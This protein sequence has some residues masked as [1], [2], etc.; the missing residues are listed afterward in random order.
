MLQVAEVTFEPLHPAVVDDGADDPRGARTADR[1]GTGPVVR[2]TP[3]A[4]C[5]IPATGR[6]RRCRGLAAIAPVV[7]AGVTLMAGVTGYAWWRSIDTGRGRCCPEPGD[8]SIAVL[9]LVDIPAA[10]GIAYLAD[11]LFS[12]EL[13]ALAQIRAASRRARRRSSSRASP[14]TCDASARRSACVTCSMRRDGDR[15]RDRAADRRGERLPRLARSY[16]RNW[17]DVFAIQGRHR[18]FGHRRTEG[19]GGGRRRGRPEFIG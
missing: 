8:A 16:D 18:A 12:E 17:S 2:I 14:S 5:S 9:P 3:V 7:V 19:G 4:S 15:A 11:G 6:R 10:G 1:R 13:S